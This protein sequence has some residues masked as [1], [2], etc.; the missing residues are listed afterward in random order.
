M[1]I[2]GIG[3]AEL[4]A[5]LVIML[6]VAGPKR[7]IQWSYTL[8]KYVAMARNMWAQTA[9]QL[10]KEVDAAG[11][12]FQVPKDI[13][14]RGSLN[15]TI[16]KFIADTAKPITQPVD[17]IK[18]DVATTRRS[19]TP[20]DPA[21]FQKARN[22]AAGMTAP[23]KAANGSTPQKPASANGTVTAT[24]PPPAPEPPAEDP[25]AGFGTWSN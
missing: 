15:A 17:E 13:P 11:V 7:M 9:Q 16:G 23:A 6:V 22:G 19:I 20:G 5:I 14:T 2:F 3:G 10:Q 8:G 12:D 1:E 24:T 21:A 25:P 4:I 18:K